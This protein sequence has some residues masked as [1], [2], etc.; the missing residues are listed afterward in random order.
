MK[1]PAQSFRVR[2]A[3]IHLVNKK[4]GVL[5]GQ[6]ANKRTVVCIL[7]LEIHRVDEDAGIG[8]DNEPAGPDRLLD[9]HRQGTHL[10]TAIEPVVCV[11]VSP[12]HDR[13]KHERRS[14]FQQ[15]C[16]V[17]CY[18]RW[19]DKGPRFLCTVG[20]DQ[21]RVSILPV[22]AG[23]VHAS[24]GY[25]AADPCQDFIAGTEVIGKEDGVSPG[26]ECLVPG[27]LPLGWTAVRCNDQEGCI[28]RVRFQDSRVEDLDCPVAIKVGEES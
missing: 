19:Y 3:G 7:R 27:N 18:L 21:V 22:K 10:F 1:N 6:V 8:Q 14:A 5:R 20:D 2:G 9:H 23:D 12:A 4:E 17:Q 26:Q 11:P 16:P 25:P 28:S 13:C 24:D 15:R